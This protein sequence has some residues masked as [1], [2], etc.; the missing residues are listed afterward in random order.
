MKYLVFTNPL[1][2]KNAMRKKVSFL[3]VGI[4]L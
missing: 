4:Q 1:K 2:K 3:I